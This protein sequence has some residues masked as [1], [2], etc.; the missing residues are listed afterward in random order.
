MCGLRCVLMSITRRSSLLI[1]QT[2]ASVMFPSCVTWT[3]QTGL[4]VMNAAA[5][6]ALGGKKRLQSRSKIT[7]LQRKAVVN[8]GKDHPSR[9]S[10]A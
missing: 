9:Q 10:R 1:H 4:K 3:L 7:A 8:L 2:P 5:V 6:C